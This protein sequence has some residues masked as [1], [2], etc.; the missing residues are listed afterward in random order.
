[1]YSYQGCATF[2]EDMTGQAMSLLPK[3]KMEFDTT[4]SCRYAG[5]YVA[6]IRKITFRDCFGLLA[7]SLDTAA[8]ERQGG[9][10]KTSEF[11]GVAAAHTTLG[12]ATQH[13]RIDGVFSTHGAVVPEL[14]GMVQRNG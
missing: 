9:S 4:L 6:G 5:S 8:G 7:L 14:G 12:E 11:E 13:S 2:G 1:M 10:G 3:E